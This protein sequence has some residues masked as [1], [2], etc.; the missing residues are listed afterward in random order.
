MLRSCY[1]AELRKRQVE[2]ELDQLTQQRIA[3]VA[4]WL[5]GDLKPALLLY[6][7]PGNGK[8]TMANAVC[9]LI[10]LLHDSPYRS[11]ALF[12]RSST[13]QELVELKLRDEKEGGNQFENRSKSPLL[14]VDDIG[15]ESPSV[16]SWGNEYM[17]I[18]ELLYW[19]YDRQLFTILTSNK[20]DAELE[21]IYGLRIADRLNEMCD[22]ISY[23]NSSYR[24]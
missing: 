14:F 2:D 7:T 4:R 23:K 11:Q 13:A 21:S 17:P 12:V 22:K 19:R 16:R 3:Q 1:I 5:R 15:T 8:T 9:Q 10:G 6:G 18:A 24:R 20:T